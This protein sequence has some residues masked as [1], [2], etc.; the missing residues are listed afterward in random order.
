MWGADHQ[1]LNNTR[2]LPSTGRSMVGRCSTAKVDFG[3]LTPNF[4]LFMNKQRRLLSALSASIHAA[5]VGR[6][7]GETRGES[8]TFTQRE[9][10]V[11]EGGRRRTGSG[12]GS[13]KA[14]TSPSG[15]FI[16]FH[17]ESSYLNRIWVFLHR[18]WFQCYLVRS[19]NQKKSTPVKKYEIYLE[20][21][22]VA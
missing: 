20:I 8:G 10:N 2:Q 1:H 13:G 21:R 3:L 16:A 4:P 22:H 11:H 12:D 5:A 17:F 18:N 15:N 14:P 7:L 19:G 9:R 6:Q